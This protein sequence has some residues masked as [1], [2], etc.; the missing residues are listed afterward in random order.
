MPSLGKLGQEGYQFYL[1][2]PELYNKTLSQKTK[3]TQKTKTK[4][5]K[6]PKKQIS[7]NMKL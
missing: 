6:D 3:E 7:V 2:Q 5:T 1:G 4:Q